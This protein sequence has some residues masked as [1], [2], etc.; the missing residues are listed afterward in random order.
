MITLLIC[1]WK[2]LLLS[3]SINPLPTIQR[4]NRTNIGITAT[5]RTKRRQ[6][7]KEN[8]TCVCHTERRKTKRRM[9]GSRLSWW[10]DGDWSL[11]Q[12]QQKSKVFCILF[13]FPVW[14]EKQFINSDRGSLK[15]FQTTVEQV[16]NSSVGSQSFLMSFPPAVL[17]QKFWDYIFFS[18]QIFS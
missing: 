8:R 2:V 11:F 1:R 9:W 14:L 15:S 4:E 18:R 16:G 17:C 7:I 10:V 5:W 13:F 12:R 3:S 6:S